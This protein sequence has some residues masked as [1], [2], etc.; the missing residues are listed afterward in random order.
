[1][2][3]PYLSSHIE[4]NT[5]SSISV[6]YRHIQ[7]PIARRALVSQKSYRHGLWPCD[8]ICSSCH[9]V[10]W[11]QERSYR[12]TTDDPLFFTCCQRGQILLPSFP[13][14]P[15]P[16]KSLLGEQPD[17]NPTFHIS[18]SVNCHQSRKDFVPMFETT[19]TL[20]HSLP[21]ES[22][23]TPQ[24]TVLPEYILFEFKDTWSIESGPFC[25]PQVNSLASPRSISM[26]LIYI[27]KLRSE[28]HIIMDSWI[29][30]QFY[31][32]NICYGSIILISMLS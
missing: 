22:M 31:S 24:Y 27:V 20:L 30:P 16:L 13:D 29:K 11:I 28:C 14:A 18:L 19:T 10:H 26:T 1:L 6:R 21:S 23:S 4:I 15:E 7:L 2:Q 5:S 32:C 8:V 17:G 9:A 12:S 25:L 3:R